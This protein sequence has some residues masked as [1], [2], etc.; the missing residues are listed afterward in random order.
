MGSRG[1]GGWLLMSL[2]MLV[3]WGGLIAVAVWAFRSF[4]RPAG[5]DRPAGPPVDAVAIL[6]ERFARGEI[7]Q[8]ELERRRDVLCGTRAAGGR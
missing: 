4:G 7:D 6:E 1:G 3:L 5:P 2:T 8:E